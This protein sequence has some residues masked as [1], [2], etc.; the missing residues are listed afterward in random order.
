MDIRT[1]PCSHNLNV[2]RNGREIFFTPNARNPLKSPDP[3]K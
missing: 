1:G 3:K 2:N